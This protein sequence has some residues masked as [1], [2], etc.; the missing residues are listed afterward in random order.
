MSPWGASCM[1]RRVVRLG[2]Q[3]VSTP[4]ILNAASAACYGSR[5]ESCKVCVF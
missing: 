4:T 2:A 3:R 5:M 1:D